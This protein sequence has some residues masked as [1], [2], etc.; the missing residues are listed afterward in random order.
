VK[1]LTIAA[2]MLA[3]V[4]L[5]GF[6]CTSVIQVHEAEPIQPGQ[7]ATFM[8]PTNG[9]GGLVIRATA[10]LPELELPASAEASEPTGETEFYILS[11]MELIATPTN[12]PPAPTNAPPVPTNAAAASQ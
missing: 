8:A 10:T 1:K 2:I 9:V 5:I 12:T 11:G 6:G 4:G 7:S 3:V